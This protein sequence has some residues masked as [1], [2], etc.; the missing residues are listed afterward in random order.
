MGCR[1][2]KVE[3]GKMKPDEYV[4]G[5]VCQDSDIQNDEMKVFKLG[6]EGD[7]LLIRQ[8]GELHALGNKCT[9]YGAPLVQSALGSG[10][11]R[12]QWHGACFNITTGDIED[13]PGLD[14]LPCY[15]VTVDDNNVKVRAKRAELQTNKR[16]K[17]LTA[18][19]AANKSHIIVVGGGP[20]AATC[21]ETLR[22]EG[23]SGKLTM[24]A[25]ENSVPYD[26]IKLSKSLDLDVK[27]AQLRPECFYKQNS[28]NVLQGKTATSV[29]TNTNEVTLSSGEVYNYSQLY[30][31]TGCKALKAKVPGADLQQVVV[32]RG[33]EDAKNANQFINPDAEVVV[34]GASFIAMEVASYCADKVKSV[35]VIGRDE[36]PFRPVLGPEIGAA[37]KTLFESKGVKFVMNSGVQACVPNSDGNLEFVELI[38]GTKLR[39]DL[40]VMGIGSGFN[41]DFLKGS[42]IEMN[43]NG[44]ITANENLQTNISNVYVGGDIAHA[45]V[46]SNCDEKSS[47]GHFG[48]AM[49]HGRIAAL[50]M[51]GKNTPLRAVPYFWTMLFGKGIRYAGHG[52]YDKILY[53][54]DVNEFKFVAYYLKGNEVIAISSCGMDPIVSQYAERRSQGK[55]LLKSELGD[56]L[57]GW[58]K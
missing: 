4:E 9:H 41:T 46:F 29:D 26:R 52:T 3:K 13:F 5:I 34:L 42:G 40:C 15:E 7:V 57:L 36:I 44:S 31:A 32:I 30:I 19:D 48:L 23:F 56:D 27:K 25:R 45:P 12:C 1:T 16:S 21:V 43:P 18:L 6:E 10:R 17:I 50:N 20:S 55:K 28:V 33:F 14:S 47:I 2:S 11:L 58:S 53:Q 38:D 37:V 35:T 24:I 8:N 39:A 54:G 51:L 49:Y 22:Q